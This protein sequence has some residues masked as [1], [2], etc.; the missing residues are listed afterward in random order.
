MA[1]A[2]ALEVSPL[3]LLMP[4]ESVDQVALTDE[5]L[6]SWQEAWRWAAGEQPLLGD[7]VPLPDRRVAQFI[8]ENR[9]FENAHPVRELSRWLLSRT[10]IVPFQA[11]VTADQQGRAKARITWGGGDEE[12]VDDGQHREAP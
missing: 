9:P 7:S 10:P 6:V 8:E 5:R 11:S 4:R 3:R 1:L 12:A 2:L